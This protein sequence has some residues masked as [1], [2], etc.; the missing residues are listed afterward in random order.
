MVKLLII[1]YNDEK[2]L[3]LLLKK[4]K[5]S[6]NTMTYGSGTASDSLLSYFGLDSIR[7]SIYFSLIPTSI[8]KNILSDLENKL[9]IKEIGKGIAFTISLTSSNK[10]IKDSLV[11]GDDLM[12]DNISSYELVISIVKEGYSDSV[13]QAA[14]K[15]GCN[16]GTLIEGRSLGTSRTIFMD[17]EIDSEKDIVLNIVS[18]DIK[19]KVMESIN[20]SC[21]IKTEARGLIIS[22]PIDSVVGLQEE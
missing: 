9:K 16:G 22:L 8:E 7:K 19:R 17:M 11:K 10:Y 3:K 18:S 13:M 12:E 4:Y 14:K 2:K 15:V 6:F 20:K 1:I 5:L 21:G